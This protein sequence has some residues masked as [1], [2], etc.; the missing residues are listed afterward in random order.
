M[1]K[2]DKRTLFVDYLAQCREFF[3][4]SRTSTLRKCFVI[5]LL[6][7]QL[8]WQTACLIYAENKVKLNNRNITAKIWHVELEIVC[9]GCLEACLQFK[10]HGERHFHWAHKIK[11][12][13]QEHLVCCF[14]VVSTGRTLYNFVMAFD[15]LSATAWK[16][17]VVWKGLCWW[18]FDSNTLCEKKSHCKL[19]HYRGHC[20]GNIRVV[21]TWSPFQLCSTSLAPFRENKK[22]RKA[23]RLIKADPGRLPCRGELGTPSMT[24]LTQETCVLFACISLEDGWL[25]QTVLFR[26][27]F[28][29]LSLFHW[30]C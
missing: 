24:F 28:P 15:M 19:L 1:L 10:R 2:E 12:I 26:T 3:A 22:K 30:N 8:V 4:R 20:W 16:Q 17:N 29:L 21:S 18:L 23:G 13:N 5:V 27:G 25:P 11:N 7:Q 14:V 9:Y 6:L